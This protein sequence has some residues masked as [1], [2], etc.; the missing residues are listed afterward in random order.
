[1]ARR[2]NKFLL[3]THLGFM[4]LLLIAV[5]IFLGIYIAE[6]VLANKILNGLTALVSAVKG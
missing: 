1:M 4:G 3:I 5:I 6:P 2:K